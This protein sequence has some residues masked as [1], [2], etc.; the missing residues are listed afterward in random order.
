MS[1]KKPHPKLSLTPALSPPSVT[2]DS[3]TYS[4]TTKVM[5]VTGTVSPSGTPV[6]G[7]C[8]NTTTQQMYMPDPGSLQVT[9]TSWS[10]TYTG[11]PSG[12]YNVQVYVVTSGGSASDQKQFTIP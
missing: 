4:G 9:G 1:K 10:M 12:T 5:T 2:I 3:I 11:L 7:M 8:R 6:S